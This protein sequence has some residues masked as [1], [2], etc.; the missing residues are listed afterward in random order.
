MAVTRA[1]LADSGN[2]KKFWPQHGRLRPY[3]AFKPSI[4]QSLEAH[5]YTMQ[6][7]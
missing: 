5:S 6:I 3:K 1:L 2:G 7:L 4:G